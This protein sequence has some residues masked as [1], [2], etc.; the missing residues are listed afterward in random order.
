MIMS[1]PFP[2]MDP[3][4]EDRHLW[5]SVHHRL[6]SAI[7]DML[8]AQVAPH[9]Y[10]TIEERV[11]ISGPDAD[12]D[13]SIVPD[14]YLVQQPLPLSA[15]LVMPHHE[16]TAPTVVQILEPLELR[17]RYIE[18]RDTSGQ[19]VV[20][21]IEVLSPRNKAPN[22][23]GRRAF[24]SK[25][26]AV[27]GAATNW[28]EIDLLRGGQ[29][30]DEVAQQSDYYALLKRQGHADHLDVWFV[31]LRDPLPVIAAPLRPPFP[32]ALLDLGAAITDVYTRGTYAVRLN[33]TQPPPSPP[34]RKADAAWVAGCIAHWRQAQREAH[35]G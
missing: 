4:L 24:L 30:P 22:A 26:R 16:P 14:V 2:G 9:F 8:T 1:S 6:I 32:D 27:M 18:V 25:R 17:D 34:L 10:V 23:K 3:Y 7:S 33:Y 20:T 28:I 5:P 12:D 13:S 19:E 29:R 15:A 21:T 31:D 11:Y 35:D